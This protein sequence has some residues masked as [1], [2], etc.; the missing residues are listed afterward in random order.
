M[1]VAVGAFICLDQSQLQNYAQYSLE[2]LY[3]K[4]QNIITYQHYKSKKSTWSEIKT[5]I[6][7][8]S[9][10]EKE[11]SST[12]HIIIYT[13]CQSFCDLLGK[14][15]A[16]LL[17]NNFITRQGKRLQNADLYQELYHIAEKFQIE[18]IKIKGHQTQNLRVTVQEKIFTILDKLSRKKLRE[19][20]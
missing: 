3:F 7:A 13:D 17:Q 18:S 12:K 19:C 9:F 2:E 8:L 10:I 5:V 20:L 16:K 1:H 6:A 4:L 15:K 11:H 14:R